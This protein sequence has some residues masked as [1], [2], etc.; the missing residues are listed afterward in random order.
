MCSSI[1][2]LGKEVNLKTLLGFLEMF[3]VEIAGATDV[4]YVPGYFPFTEPSIKIHIKHPIAL[5]ICR[6]DDR[7]YVKPGRTFMLQTRP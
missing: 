2:V 1:F 5:P 7:L 4:K 3:A 6:R